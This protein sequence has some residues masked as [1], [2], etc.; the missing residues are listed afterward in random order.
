MK[1]CRS[2][3]FINVTIVSMKSVYENYN[4]FNTSICDIRFI[5]FRDVDKNIRVVDI[6]VNIEYHFIL[7]VY[8]LS[9][10]YYNRSR[11]DQLLKLKFTCCKLLFS[12]LHLSLSVIFSYTCLS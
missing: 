11:Y 8:L 4:N 10:H 1:C 7:S 6:D 5:S 3:I 2:K 12:L 9:L